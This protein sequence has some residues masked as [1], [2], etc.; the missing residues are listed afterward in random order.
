LNT[1]VAGVGDD[2]YVAVVTPAEQWVGRRSLQISLN[3]D[4]TALA[5]PR[6][7][8]DGDVK[9]GRYVSGLVN[10]VVGDALTVGGP[11]WR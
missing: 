10:L 1:W 7:V 8:V 3:E 5:E 9:G 11:W 6:L 4:G 2:G